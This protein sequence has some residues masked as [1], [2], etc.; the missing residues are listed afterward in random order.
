MED[1]SVRITFAFIKAT[2]GILSVDPYFQRNWREAAKAGIIC[3]AYHYFKP[4]RSGSLQAR[5]FLQTAKAEKGDLPMVVDV[6][7]LN[8]VSPEQMR[9]QLKDFLDYIGKKS[10]V[11]P[12]IYSGLSFYHDYLQGYFDE[13]PLWVAKYDQPELGPAGNKQ[14]IIWQHSDKATITGINHVVDFDAF[15]GDS[16]A[17]R[18][19]LIR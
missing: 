9:R 1:D 7:E 8:R 3:G 4:S 13:Y 6:E 16:L 10:K 19:L 15:N 17:F 14:W 2:E 18:Q 11:K 5:F 12:I